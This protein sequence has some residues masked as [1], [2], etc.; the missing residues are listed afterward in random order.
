[1]LYKLQNKC[2]NFNNIQNKTIEEFEY[3]FI[4]NYEYN[5]TPYSDENIIF[6]IYVTDYYQRDILLN[7]NSLNF[8]LEYSIDGE[9]TITKNIKAGDN[10]IDIGTLPVGEHY[11]TFQVIDRGVKSHKLYNHVLVKD[12]NKVLN[13]YQMTEEDLVIYNINN[14]NSEIESDMTNTRLGISQIISN[15]KN[16]GY[17]GIKL[18]YGYYRVNRD[19][20]SDSYDDMVNAKPI[21]IP[22]NF[23]LDLNGST[24][25]HHV[26]EGQ[27]STIISFETDCINSEVTNGILIGDYGEHSM[28]I[29]PD[30][31]YTWGESAGSLRLAHTTFCTVNN[32]TIKDVQGYSLGLGTGSVMAFQPYNGGTYGIKLVNG[33]EINDDR[34]TTT[35]LTEIYTN[36]RISKNDRWLSFG[37]YGGVNFLKGDSWVINISFYDDEQTFLY[38]EV[39]YQYRDTLIPMNAK[40]VRV[41]YLGDITENIPNTGIISA[42]HSRCNSILNVSSVHTRT[43]AITPTGSYLLVKNCKFEDCATQTTPITIDCEDGWGY[44]Y[45]M[46]FIDNE[47]IS[48]AAGTTGNLL[49]CYGNN[50]VCKGNKNF[51]IIMRRGVQRFYAKNE[52]N[53][54]IRRDLFPKNS[55]AFSCYDQIIDCNLKEYVDNNSSTDILHEK[56]ISN[57][58][59]DNSLIYINNNDI[60]RNSSLYETGVGIY[61]DCTFLLSNKPVN[62]CIGKTKIY[63]SIFKP[64]FDD[65]S[66]R[67]IAGFANYN[68][69]D[70][71]IYNCKF[72]NKCELKGVGKSFTSGKF[73]NCIFDDLSI[74]ISE[75][76]KPGDKILFKDCDI[77]FSGDQ[78]VYYNGGGA[79]NLGR[80]NKLEFNNCKIR[81]MN[82]SCKY[83]IYLFS[84]PEGMCTFNNCTF[85]NCENINIIDVRHF[86][87]ENFLS[88]Y[89]K[90][91]DIDRTNIKIEEKDTFSG[92]IKIL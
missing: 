92:K 33:I 47:I 80:N 73:I 42:H 34:Y 15:K 63:N 23:I 71:Y 56:V 54:T 19:R 11:I 40:Y 68:P 82:D 44:M 64:N 5:F 6:P 13:I 31:G 2:I 52:I 9:E 90:L 86:K 43:C 30:T 50:F 46:Y 1:M 61:R 66:L 67:Y 4:S 83:L 29:N 75:L 58:S 48:D 74:T 20:A 72:E 57:S 59:I 76:A 32:L 7:D 36:G 62:A 39:G 88:Y 41:T 84:Y 26:F 10:I 65:S 25:K 45:D 12:R 89:V 35:G 21:T 17:D 3:P 37:S 78:L 55:R 51:K 22:S 77:S 85:E 87:I 38:E 81:C 8:I 27:S 70:I 28:E 14:E 60:I 79:Y 18:L 53:G 16:E 91:I 24:I 69:I 49:A